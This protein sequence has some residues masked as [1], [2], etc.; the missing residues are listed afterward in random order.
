MKQTIK[1]YSGCRL[2]R[3]LFSL[4]Y[5]IQVIGLL[6]F[7]TGC[8]TTINAKTI[9][10]N[11]QAINASDQNPGT[12]A[13]PLKTIQ[14]GADLAQP[15]DT[16]LVRGGIYREE[17][18][19]PRGGTSSKKT[20]VYRAARGEEV[21]IRGSEQITSWVNQ[22]NNIWMVELDT[23][24]F[25]GYNP[26]A[27]KIIGAWLNFVNSGSRLG[28]VYFNGEAYLQQFDIQDLSISNT[29]YTDTTRGYT[30]RTDWPEDRKYTNG[31]IQIFANF[32]GE[33]P[34]TNLTEINARA[35]GIFPDIAGLK[36]IV[37][38]GFDIRHTAP[39]WGDIYFT[40]KGAIGTAMGYKWTIQN[41]RITN[42]RNLGISMGKIDGV[43]SWALDK[44]GSHLIRNNI[45]KRC[46]QCGIYGIYGAAGSIIEGN[47]IYETNYRNEWW[48]QNQAAIK[49]LLGV[50]V[51]IRHNHIFSKQGVNLRARGIWMDNGCQNSRV[52]GNVVYDFA[53]HGAEGLKT[54]VNHG[55]IMVD[56]NVFVRSRICEE[57]NGILVVHNLFLDCVFWFMSSPTRLSPYYEPHS[58]AQSGREGTTLRHEKIYNNIIIG[59]KGLAGGVGSIIRDRNGGN[60]SGFTVNNNVYL[61]GAGKF[62][63]QDDDSVVD[64][65]DV[66]GKFIHNVDSIMVSYNLPGS[67]LS[68]HY[69]LITSEFMGKVPFTK[70]FIENPDGTPLD[71]MS[72]YYGNSV[73]PNNV[74]PGPFQNIT[75]GANTFSLW[76]ISCT[77]GLGN[78]YRVEVYNSL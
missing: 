40:E 52:T 57:G 62:D 26:F 9:V 61:N 78:N 1:G 46:G 19:P 31:K 75:E 13:Q 44:V 59:G 33:N 67:V 14:A 20:I 47:V 3:T 58:T 7:V 73:D 29:W 60:A 53:D 36:Y 55:P 38:D 28:D 23:S 34:N 21:S 4:F 76:P 63:Y 65:F 64:C 41:C 37:I 30:T 72:D 18:H 70:M 24:F 56:N 5:H 27:M 54:E 45:I 50:D 68:V 42:S 71:I 16:I 10:V 66:G 22:G 25:N 43:N 35:A 11:N 48:G 49:I 17:V 74:M 12:E 8:F 77:S 69:P 6:L 15:G 2:L 51:I 32:G 39:Q